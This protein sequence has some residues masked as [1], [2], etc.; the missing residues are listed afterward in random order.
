MVDDG[1]LIIIN[2]I[3]VKDTPISRLRLRAARGG[4]RYERG[5]VE[6]VA[7]AAFSGSQLK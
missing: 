6:G 1:C 2:F 5:R 7:E 3:N 4:S